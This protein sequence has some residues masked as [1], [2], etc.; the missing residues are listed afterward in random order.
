MIWTSQHAILSTEVP[1]LSPTKLHLCLPWDAII[2]EADTAESWASL[3]SNHRPKAF[4]PVLKTYLTTA[5]RNPYLLNSF[6]CIIILHGLILIALDLQSCEQMT[7]EPITFHSKP[8]RFLIIRAY[9]TWKTAFDNFTKVTISTL[10]EHQSAEFQKGCTATLALY[11]VASIALYIPLTDLQIYAGARHILG[12]YIGPA[13]QARAIHNVQNWAASGNMDGAVAVS[14]AALLIRDGITK[15][16]NWDAGDAFHYPWCLYLATLACWA[17]MAGMP[18]NRTDAYPSEA[19]N[20]VHS[21][22]ADW[23]AK[24]EMN[25]LISA[26]TRAKPEDLWRIRGRYRVYD[27][28]R[29]IARSLEGVRWAVV[30]EGVLVLRGLR[31]GR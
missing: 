28:P 24:A 5:S 9:E 27:L 29:V 3:M 22:D 11:H 20:H 31:Q 23:D 30:Q 6:S 14:H 17:F 16:Q 2:W 21:E 1:S 26:I 13:E 19:T 10:P 18:E 7:T 4:L 12:R 15:L 8:W 25:A